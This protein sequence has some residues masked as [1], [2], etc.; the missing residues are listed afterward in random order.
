MRSTNFSID[1]TQNKVTFSSGIGGKFKTVSDFTNGD[2]DGW[3]IYTSNGL[4]SKVVSSTKTGSQINLILDVLDV[5]NYSQD[6][7]LTFITQTL[8]V[9]PDADSIE[10]EFKPEVTDGVTQ[11][12]QYFSFP[13]NTPLA[14]SKVVVYKSPSVF[15]YLSYRYKTV[16]EFTDWEKIPSDTISGYYEES[17]FNILDGVIT[18]SPTKKT[19]NSGTSS[20]F[21]ELVLSP[22]ALIN[23]KN[24][25]YKGDLLE[26]ERRIW[27]YPNGTL[28]YQCKVGLHKQYQVFN[29]NIVGPFSYFTNHVIIDLD[30]VKL[31]TTPCVNGNRWVFWLRDQI[32]FVNPAHTVKFVTDYVNPTTFTLVYELT[33][34]DKDF[35]NTS[36]LTQS[37]PYQGLRLEFV[38]DGTVWDLDHTNENYKAEIAALQA[39]DVSLT[40]AILAIAAPWVDVPK[41]DWGDLYLQGVKHTNTTPPQNISPILL[42]NTDIVDFYCRKK[43]VGKTCHLEFKLTVDEVNLFS[44]LGTGYY[45][46]GFIFEGFPAALEPKHGTL[47]FSAF[48]QRKQGLSPP[49]YLTDVTLDAWFDTNSPTKKLIG[50]PAN[51]SPFNLWDNTG[52]PYTAYFWEGAYSATQSGLI[53]FSITYELP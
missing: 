19:Y 53:S 52:T 47:A 3:R 5:D 9:V 27:D 25:V 14:Q 7:G 17:S 20:A 6:G 16:K 15:Y 28:Y 23:F 31:D 45:F 51:Q 49:L 33:T 43:V 37:T 40:N 32:Q 41:S 1:T 10:L 24:L 11:L 22:L 26:L 29:Y 39:V 12:D 13:I 30:K 4:Y 48:H 34:K 8:L 2:F 21:I 46:Y 50:Q 42:T 18:G 35:I 38:Y 44:G 36:A